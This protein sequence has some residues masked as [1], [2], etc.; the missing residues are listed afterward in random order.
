MTDDQML[1]LQLYGVGCVLTPRCLCVYDYVK[2]DPVNAFRIHVSIAKYTVNAQYG[3]LEMD[4]RDH[5]I[6]IDQTSNCSLFKFVDEMAS[7]I[8]WVRG[9]QLVV[10]GIGVLTKK[11]GQN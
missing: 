3:M 6:C 4:D 7:K 5:D 9:H 8:I 11:V 2:I 10:W 1:V